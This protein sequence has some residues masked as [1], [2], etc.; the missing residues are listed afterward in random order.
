MVCLNL[1]PW[2]RCLPGFVVV[3]GIVPADCKNKQTFLK[4]IADQFDALGD[5]YG[6]YDAY[7]MKQVS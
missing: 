1:P 4:F 5:G 2:I 3:V 7:E 6:A